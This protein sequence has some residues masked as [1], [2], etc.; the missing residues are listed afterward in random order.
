M[1]FDLTLNCEVQPQAKAHFGLD[2]LVQCQNIFKHIDL[3]LK[4]FS[5]FWLSIRIVYSILI[6][7]QNFFLAYWPSPRVISSMTLFLFHRH[8][9]GLSF[10]HQ[11][12]AFDMYYSSMSRS[13]K[14][15]MTQGQICMDNQTQG[16]MRQLIIPLCV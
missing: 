15:S 10:L 5:T 9:W 14:T 6:Q 4:Y 2:I 11:A 8:G 1:C 7:D 12:Q 16:L 13:S 3:G